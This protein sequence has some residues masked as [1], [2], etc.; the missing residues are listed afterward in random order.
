MI[1][2]NHQE[3]Q[4]TGA[5]ITAAH[6]IQEVAAADKAPMANRP[7]QGRQTLLPQSLRSALEQVANA[8]AVAATKRRQPKTTALVAIQGW[9]SVA[10]RIPSR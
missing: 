10:F 7:I 9:G 1:K 5:I 6:V 2:E 4:R 8:A 3:A